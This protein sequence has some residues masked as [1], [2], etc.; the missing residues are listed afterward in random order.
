VVATIFSAVLEYK[1]HYVRD[2]TANLF[3]YLSIKAL[4]HAGPSLQELKG[5]SYVCSNRHNPYKGWQ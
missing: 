3:Q 4:H 5:G 2:V 1:S